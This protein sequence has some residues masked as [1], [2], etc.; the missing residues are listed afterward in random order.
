[1]TQ[2]RGRASGLIDRARLRWLCRRGM[3]E[4]DELLLRFLERELDDRPAAEQATFAR[5][6]E[7][8]DPELYALICGRIQ[9]EDPVKADVLARIRRAA[10]A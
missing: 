2:S 3:K 6:L 9:A 4:L 5:L 10:D 8:E 1:M 7:C